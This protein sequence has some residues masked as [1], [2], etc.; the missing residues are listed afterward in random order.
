[1]YAICCAMFLILPGL[2]LYPLMLGKRPFVRFH[3]VFIPAFLA[4]AAVWCTAWFGLHFHGKDW[5]GSLG[6]SLAFA[7]VILMMLGNVRSLLRVGL[8]LF[9]THSAGYFSGGIVHGMMTG[10]PAM[11]A[12]GICYG[13]GFGLGIGYAFYAAQNDTLKTAS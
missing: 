9:V 1:M 2:L 6:G 10:V 8:V 5:L 7:F 12:W 11:L 4:Y 3:L 13:L